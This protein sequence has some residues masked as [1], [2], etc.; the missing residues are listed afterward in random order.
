MPSWEGFT[1]R[2]PHTE[3]NE[4]ISL[5]ERIDV[6]HVGGSHAQDS[7]IVAVPDSGVLLLGDSIYPPPFHLNN[8]HGEG[9]DEPLIR[10]LLDVK[11]FGGHEW[12]VDSHN[13]PRS[14]TTLK[15]LL[16]TDAD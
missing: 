1:V 9:Y 15:S 6:H 13:N 2:P 11:E 12:Y 4:K 5:P 16:K 14:R 7:T 8:E 3:F 10:R